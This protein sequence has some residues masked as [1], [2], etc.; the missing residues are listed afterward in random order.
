MKTCEVSVGET[1]VV[2]TESGTEYTMLKTNKE[3]YSVTRINNKRDL[4]KPW[5][6]VECRITE[7]I[8][9]GSK[10]Y[11][12][13]ADRSACLLTTPVLSVEVV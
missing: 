2:K 1:V 12:F 13:P 10:F 6:N 9:V 11:L 3:C 7:D 4:R 8:D 5:K